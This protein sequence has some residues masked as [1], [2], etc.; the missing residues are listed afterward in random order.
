LIPSEKK[1]TST[2]QKIFSEANY[3]ILGQHLSRS[4]ISNIRNSKFGLDNNK[5]IL[6]Q[7]KQR[8]T[9]FSISTHLAGIATKT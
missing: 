5:R 2:F 4:L 3:L 6:L 1:F 8:L 9:R 7:S